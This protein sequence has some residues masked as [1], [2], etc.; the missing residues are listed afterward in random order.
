MKTGE[1]ICATFI[2]GLNFDEALGN[3]RDNKEL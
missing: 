2:D 1:S 3:G